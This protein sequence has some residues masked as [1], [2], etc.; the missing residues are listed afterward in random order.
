MSRPFSYNDENFTVIGN[1]LLC[2]IKITLPLKSED[3]IIE[4]PPA[5][6]DRLLHYANVFSGGFVGSNDTSLRF[7][8]Y[9]QQHDNGKYY[10]HSGSTINVKD[11]AYAWSIYY[12]KDI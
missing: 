8:C 4:V 2:H 7:S 1:F 10:L 9:V 3:I 6:V 11:E 5:I 12:L